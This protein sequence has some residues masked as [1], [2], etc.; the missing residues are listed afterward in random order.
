M[1]VVELEYLA[2]SLRKLE[3]NTL[4]GYAAIAACNTSS[5]TH[6]ADRPLSGSDRHV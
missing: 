2:C 5:S 3:Q 6:H 4:L 1:S